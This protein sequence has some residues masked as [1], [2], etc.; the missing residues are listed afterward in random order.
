MIRAII[1]ALVLFLVSF[2]SIAPTVPASFFHKAKEAAC[3]TEALWYEARGESLEG[4]QSVLSV[5]HNR[6]IKN[7]LDYCAVIHQAKQFSYR[8]K[9]AYGKPV[10]IKVGTQKST[11]D[12]IHSLVSLAVDGKFVP[13]LH[14]DVLWYHNRKVN[15]KWNRKM[16]KVKTV[17]NH[18]FWKKKG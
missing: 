7:N 18:I 8:N 12:Q 9:Q 11:L 2:K 16:Q 10:V 6:K 3:L 4:I 13:N 5:I 1:L 17:G 15:P 14:S